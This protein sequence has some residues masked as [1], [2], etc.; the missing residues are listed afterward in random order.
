MAVQ[1]DRN[2]YLFSFGGTSCSGLEEWQTGLRFAP[3]AGTEAAELLDQLGAISMEDCFNACG[4]VIATTTIGITH[5]SSIAAKWAKLAVIKQDGH[6]AGA[7]SIYE[8]NRPG[9]Y[10]GGFPVP[11]QLAWA[12]TLGTG[13]S[14]GMAQKGRMYW[15]VPTNAAQLLMPT[16]GQT[17]IGYTNS[18][19][20]AIINALTAVEGEITTVNV[21]VSAAVMS[22]SGGKSNPAGVGTTNYVTEVSLGRVLDTQRSRRTNLDEAPVQVPALRGLRDTDLRAYEPRGRRTPA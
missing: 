17:D 8:G 3:D 7:P 10:S 1:Y 21:S 11:P 19:R 15:P 5:P 18:Y 22:S 9:S 4:A 14:F 6:Y 16:T 2:H 13:K 12:I 20:T